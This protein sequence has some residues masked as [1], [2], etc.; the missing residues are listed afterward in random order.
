ML[1]TVMRAN[2]LLGPASS[3]LALAMDTRGCWEGTTRAEGH[4]PKL[5]GTRFALPF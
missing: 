3:E 1:I 4:L 2:Y 5:L